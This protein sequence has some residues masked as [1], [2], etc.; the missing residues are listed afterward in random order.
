ML[1]SCIFKKIEDDY[2]DEFRNKSK[3]ENAT[4]GD[5]EELMMEALLL[6][7]KTILIPYR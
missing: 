2:D 6:D 5:D 1:F 3:E 4:A 7:G